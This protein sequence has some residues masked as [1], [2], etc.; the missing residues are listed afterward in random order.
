MRPPG[1]EHGLGGSPS[2]RRN[3]GYMWMGKDADLHD[4]PQLVPEP[5]PLGTTKDHHNKDWSQIDFDHREEIS[6][7][8]LAE[9]F[10]F[11][12]REPPRPGQ[13]SNIPRHPS[14]VKPPIKQLSE[15]FEIKVTSP[16][17]DKIAVPLPRA[18]PLNLPELCLPG[19]PTDTSSDIPEISE[20]FKP[21]RC[22]VRESDMISDS[23]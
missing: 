16:P 14:L 18:S 12:R 3:P 21:V 11:Q 15:S 1:P 4:K 17:K 9:G 10:T 8:S 5:N 23:F 13:F 2:S 6:E 20:K 22:N 7:A 19:K